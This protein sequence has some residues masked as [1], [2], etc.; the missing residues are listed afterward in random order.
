MIVDPGFTGEHAQ[1][2]RT[3]NIGTVTQPKELVMENTLERRHQV[4]IE[5]RVLIE[6]PLVKIVHTGKED[7]EPE[8]D[9]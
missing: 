6:V 8:V 1:D 7:Q 2:C 9:H 5:N 3:V 4:L